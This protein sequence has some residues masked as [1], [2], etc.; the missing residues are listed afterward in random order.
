MNEYYEVYDGWF[1]F[2]VNNETGE[3]KFELDEG[4]VIV[5]R[6]WDDEQFSYKVEN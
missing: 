4:D 6:C 2:F 1:T 5:P 3:K